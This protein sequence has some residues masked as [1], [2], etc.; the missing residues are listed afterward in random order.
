[1]TCYKQPEL[2]I[3]TI[4]I[5]DVISCSGEEKPDDIANDNFPPKGDLAL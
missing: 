4:E 3:L 5:C 1:M 2:H